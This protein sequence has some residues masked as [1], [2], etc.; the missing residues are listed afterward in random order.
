MAIPLFTFDHPPFFEARLPLPPG[1]NRSYKIVTVRVTGCATLAASPALRQFKRD[2][3]LSLLAEAS[4]QAEVL[5]HIRAM[6][7]K[8]RK[9]PLRIEM[10][11]H[12][13]TM[14]RRDVDGGEKHA[15]DAVCRHLSINDNQVV[16]T[17][18][19]KFLDA[20]NPRVE[21]RLYCAS[22]VLSSLL[23]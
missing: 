6:N 21:V 16:E 5:A 22:E 10:D 11:F 12:L 9:A 2:A 23:V 8:G 1:I 4:C 19:R 20:R 17:A 14:W 3:E 7:E 18:A 15:I 13:P